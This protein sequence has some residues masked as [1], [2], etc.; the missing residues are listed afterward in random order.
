MGAP[1]RG[2]AGDGIGKGV[3]EEGA[4]ILGATDDMLMRE[5]VEELEQLICV[6]DG[7]ARGFMPL[8]KE[9]ERCGLGDEE[10]EAGL[11]SI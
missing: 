1:R 11:E 5:K 3:E 10:I 2:S 9:E 6:E 4:R 8:R 7:G